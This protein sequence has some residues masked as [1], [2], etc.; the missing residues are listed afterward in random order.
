VNCTTTQTR[1]WVFVDDCG[2][3]SA[4]F[5][6]TIS[7]T[8]DD[9]APTVNGQT[10]IDIVGCNA[11]SGFVDPTATDNCGPATIANGYPQTSAPT[12]VN[13]VTS[14]T[15]TWVFADACGNLSAPFSQTLT[16]TPGDFVVPGDGSST[17]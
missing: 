5:V 1:T 8:T 3:Q 10:N 15:R 7:W 9:V 16:F 4:P 13:C 11:G 17:V 14:Q 2:N 12:T 6:Q